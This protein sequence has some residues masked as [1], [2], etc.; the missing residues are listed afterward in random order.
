MS[1]VAYNNMDTYLF[2]RSLLQDEFG[3]VLDGDKEQQITDKLHAVVMDEG[4]GSLDVLTE[5]MY[6]EGAA[7]LRSQVL[8]AITEYHVDWFSHP[9]IMSV[10]SQYVLPNIDPA[11]SEPFRV[12]LVGCGRGQMAFSLAI[13]ADQYRKANGLDIDIEILATDGSEQTISNA[14]QASFYESFLAG[15]KEED[16]NRYLSREGD[17]WV[18]NDDIRSMV[19]FSVQNIS[20]FSVGQMPEIDLVVCPDVLTYFTVPMKAHVLEAFAETLK[21]AGILLAGESEPILPFSKQYSLVEHSS[22]VFYRKRS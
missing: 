16:I 11:R 7:E 5:R 3:V 14:A 22:G 8:N 15:L 18:V 9:G 1:S 12:W 10:F 21:P 13:A 6:G 20:E 4:G 17:Q 2:L 19:K